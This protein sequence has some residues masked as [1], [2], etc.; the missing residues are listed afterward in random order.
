MAPYSPAHRRPR[1]KL[2]LDFNENTVGCSPRVIEFSSSSLT[3]KTLA[4]YPEYEPAPPRRWPQF[5]QV[6][7][8]RSS[9]HQRHRRSHPGPHQHLRRRRR[10][11]AHPQARP[12]PCTAST[13]KWPAPQIRE[14][15][16]RAGD[17]AFPLARA[18]RPPSARDQGHPHLQ[19]QQPHRH[20]HRPRRHR[21]HPR[22]RAATPPCSS[23][24]PT[25]SSAASPRCRLIDRVPQPLRQPHVLQGLRHGRHARRLPVLAGGQRRL[26]AQGAVALQREHRW[27]PWPRAPPSQTP[28]TSTTTSAKSSPPASCSTPGFEKLRHPLL[29]EPGQLRALPRRRPRHRSPRR[30]ARHAASWSA[31]AATKSPAACAS[32]S[33]RANR[34]AAL[35][36]RTR[37]GLEMN[38]Q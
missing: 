34:C 22:S 26:P 2:R 21:A 38:D 28:T 23:T 4:V 12:T 37:G 33:A 15:A 24:K 5:F 13:P 25:T 30:P 1:G 17:L 31:T 8:G 32:P 7:A 20:R 35:P 3:P 11:R 10:R 18:A 9:P 27:P 14:I 16:Y 6:A 19:P 29:S 36:R